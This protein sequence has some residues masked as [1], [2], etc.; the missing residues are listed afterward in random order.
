[1]PTDRAI[2]AMRPGPRKAARAG[3]PRLRGDGDGGLSLV[4]VIVAFAVIGTVMTAMAP[5]LVKTVV[6]MAQQRGEQAA[7][8]I[9]ND[10]LERARALKPSSLLS[11]R[12]KQ[13]TDAQWAAAAGPVGGYL[14]TMQQAWDTGA[15][16]GAG[17]AA[18][19]PTVPNVVTI[20]GVAYE[21][22]WYVGNCWQPRT[23][24]TQTTIVVADCAPA[25][26]NSTDVALF[27]VVVAVT[28]DVA[29]SMVQGSCQAGVCA[30]VASTLL[31]PG[32]DPIFDIKRPP[33]TIS[34][35]GNQ[36][37]YVGDAVSLPL[38]A[39]GGWLPRTWTAT[40]LP[41]GLSMASST[42]VISGTPTT[43]GSYPSVT[44]VVKDRDNKTDDVVFTWVITQPPVLTSP[45][46]Q[47][48]H[49]GI[50]VSLSI[51][52]TGGSSPQTW[53]A[54]GLPAGLSINA[55]TGVISGTPTTAQTTQP[56]TVTV[57]DAG[58]K[59]AP[60]TFGWRVLT[61]FQVTSSG[62]QT[63]ARGSSPA[64]FSLSASGG[65][66]PYTWQATGLPDGLTMS[67]AGVVTGTATHGTRYV[68]TAVATDSTGRIGTITVVWDV[69]P[70]SNDL[71]I[72]SPLGDLTS[73]ISGSLPPNAAGN[74]GNA[75]GAAGRTWSA[76]GLPGGVTFSSAG[77][78]GGKPG[79]VG[80]YLVKI[81]ATDNTGGVANSMFVWTVTP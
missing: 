8:E 76:T 64:G 23:D 79:A 37:S 27:R 55:T 3:D 61:P 75:Q 39:T 81:T 46:D 49:V 16:A 14:T 68:M 71:R 28:W 48:S 41:P 13:A 51:A 10:A 60:V 31:S 4:E 18:P 45:G 57:T 26:V 33:P 59:T 22:H 74:R 65:V 56:V 1:M 9:A 20:S 43:A 42:G 11:G 17:S 80:T 58:K 5:F 67:S 12:S 32:K 7:V 77:V 54:T 66:G 2:S 15:V 50:A 52:V 47:T 35:P 30:Y 78:F 19:L 34:A 72:T 25:L 36:V 21:Q 29:S 63:L 44:V 53:S 69:T 70:L 40:G 24:P 73:K 62:A 6:V 38:T